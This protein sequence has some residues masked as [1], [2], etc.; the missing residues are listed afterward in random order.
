MALVPGGPNTELITDIQSEDDHQV[1][2]GRDTW[3]AMTFT[4]TQLTN[5]WRIA[6]KLG[7]LTALPKYLEY[8]IRN[9]VDGKPNGADLTSTTMLQGPGTVVAGG[10]WWP[11]NFPTW[12]SLDAGTWALVLR[13]PGADAPWLWYARARTTLPAGMTGKCWKST[14]KGATWTQVSDSF[15]LFQ[16]WGHTPPPIGGRVPY[17]R[18]FYEPWG[19]TL[20]ENN[21]WQQRVPML[22]ITYDL[23]DGKI[24]LSEPDIDGAGIYVQY[25]PDDI[26]LVHP[27]GHN[28]FCKA[29]SVAPAPMTHDAYIPIFI[30]TTDGTNWY[31]LELVITRGGAWGPWGTLKWGAPATGGIDYGLAPGIADLTELWKWARQTAGLST[32]PTGW[33]LDNLALVIEAIEYEDNPYLTNDS[34]ELYYSAPPIPD[35]FLAASPENAPG[36]PQAVSNWAPVDYQSDGRYEG[37]KVVVTT[38][39]P[40]HAYMRYSLTPPRKHKV[41]R[42]RRGLAVPWNTYYC[43]VAWKENEQEEKG[44]TLIHTFIKENWPFCQTRWFYFTASKRMYPTPSASPIYRLHRDTEPTPYPVIEVDA[45]Q[46]NRSIRRSWGTWPLTHDFPTGDVGPWHGDPWYILL[47]NAQRTVSWWVHRSYLRFDTSAIPAG[48]YIIDALLV[49]YV[50]L[51]TKT[52]QVAQRHIIATPGVQD[53]PVVPENYGDQLP[54]TTNLGQVH[55]DDCTVDEVTVINLNDTGKT[56]IVPEGHTLFCIRQQLDVVDIAPVIGANTLGYGS[57]QSVLWQRPKLVVRYIPPS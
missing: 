31:R 54:I 7:Y 57:A 24:T 49:L 46:D 18:P 8:A 5:S 38:D 9:T 29:I 23:A 53:S 16:V 22:P 3:L 11:Q 19:A 25:A 39:T 21:P 33:Y 47:A 12:P 37:F 43:F 36:P 48:S 14:N 51:V 20:D 34:V 10:L 32:D 45:E 4:L 52:A 2:F 15:L 30:D 26:P 6:A 28:L 56:W 17:S 1:T 13:V 40:C 55:L 35:P 27:A 50:K 42:Y 41:T 44:D